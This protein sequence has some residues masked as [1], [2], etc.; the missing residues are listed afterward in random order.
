M[1][2]LPFSV[3]LLAGTFGILLWS[4][5]PRPAEPISPVQQEQPAASRPG[6]PSA[7][8]ACAASDQD[9]APRLAPPKLALDRYHGFADHLRELGMAEGSVREITL[10][11]LRDECIR[12][13]AEALESEPIPYWSSGFSQ[14]EGSLPE[15]RAI[16]L[17]EREAA[18]QL[19]G[20]DAPLELPGAD[21]Q[22]EL[23]VRG[24][25]L[26]KEKWS[27]ILQ[28]L[29]RMHSAHEALLRSPEDS[30]EEEDEE[31]TDVAQT[32]A[33]LDQELDHALD[34]LLTPQERIEFDLRNSPS[35]HAVRLDLREKGIEVSREEFREIYEARRRYDV[36]AR[37]G[38]DLASAWESYTARASAILGSGRD[39]M[40]N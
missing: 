19:F 18:V 3:I 21:H 31:P 9:D 22:H 20:L 39:I 12:L 29:V 27:E 35:A 28:L 1:K 15:F 4:G 13:R 16:D 8:G 40:R 7:R 11:V 14:D 36:T 34:R 17:A 33:T 2:L 37:A 26:L 25:P 30:E 6:K 10:E 23:S 32:F 38:G 24:G 5:G